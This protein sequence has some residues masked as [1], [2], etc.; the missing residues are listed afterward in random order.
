MKNYEAMKAFL[1]WLINSHEE[2]IKREAI[3]IS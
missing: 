1:I 3:A 2:S